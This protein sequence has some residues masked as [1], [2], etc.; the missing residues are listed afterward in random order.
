VPAAWKM[1]RWAR[2]AIA[3]VSYDDQLE[4]ANL[5]LSDELEFLRGKGFALKSDKSVLPFFVQ[6]GFHPKLGARPMHDTIEKLI[7]DPRYNAS[8]N[9]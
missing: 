2:K 7:G 1:C 8:P 5:L 3:L 4:V 9:Q 6:C